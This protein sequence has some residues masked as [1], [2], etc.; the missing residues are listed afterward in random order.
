MRWGNGNWIH[1]TVFL[2]RCEQTFSF[3][4][5][6]VMRIYL[7]LFKPN[8][9]WVNREKAHKVILKPTR[10]RWRRSR[11]NRLWLNGLT[12]LYP[13]NH[14]NQ[15]NCLSLTSRH[16]TLHTLN[17]SFSTCRLKPGVWFMARD[18][19]HTGLILE[20]VIAV[21]FCLH[22]RLDLSEGNAAKR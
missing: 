10:R 2:R 22:T 21:T 5:C 19:R 4:L 3:P 6:C 8:S 13:L 12:I 7:N 17:G 15:I 18:S 20:F 1:F 9:V 11:T 14:V 16:S